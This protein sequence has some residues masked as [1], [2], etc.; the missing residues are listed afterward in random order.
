M[1]TT[2]NLV[3]VIIKL[4]TSVQHSHN[5]FGSRH[6]FFRV[7][8]GG[9]AAPVIGYS[10]RFVYMNNDLNLVTK[11]GQS[12]VN[13]VI[14]QLKHHM[15]QACTVIRITNIHAGAFSYR[16]QTFQDFYTGRV[17]SIFFTHLYSSN[18]QVI[19][20]LLGYHSIQI[21]CR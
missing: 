7:N 2:G 15:V 10:H 8:I 4:A 20:L 9:N 12:F 11:A 1:Q 16:I 19:S 14:D 18:I 13:T 5:D 21:F 6:A 3:G 17:I